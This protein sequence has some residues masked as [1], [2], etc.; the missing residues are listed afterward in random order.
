MPENQQQSQLEPQQQQ[1]QQQLS[2]QDSPSRQTIPQANLSEEDNALGINL[3]RRL[4]AQLSDNQKNELRTSLQV[5]MEPEIYQKY[6]SQEEDPLFLYYRY[7]SLALLR[8]KKQRRL[9]E[10][11]QLATSQP[12]QS[13]N[14]RWFPPPMQQQG[15]MNPKLF[16]L[17]GPTLTSRDSVQYQPDLATLQPSSYQ[18]PAS[19][20]L[21]YNHK[22]AV[23]PQALDSQPYAVKQ[24]QNLPPVELFT[25]AQMR[26]LPG[27]FST[28]D[29]LKWEKGLA[30]LWGCLETYGPETLKYQEA[31]KKLI[32]FSRVLWTELERSDSARVQDQQQQNGPVQTMAN[33]SR[34]IPLNA[35]PQLGAVTGSSS[36]V[37]QPTS[38]G[39][40]RN[41]QIDGMTA[42]II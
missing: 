26:T 35:T 30:V 10:A 1:Q 20:G 42:K 24:Q 40:I 27:Y 41:L 2:S 25:P 33:A 22:P 32:Q 39:K 16:E 18:K 28:E 38:L 11:Q 9:A 3:A 21:R 31:G 7:R 6:I 14:I 15:Y 23:Q 19:V 34:D 5:N 36:L 29:K 17:A 8:D 12:T 13:Q 4:M 37:S